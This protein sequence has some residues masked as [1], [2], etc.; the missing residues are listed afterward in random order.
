MTLL[1][2]EGHG[3]AGGV[4]ADEVVIVLCLSMPRV[5]TAHSETDGTV[6]LVHEDELQFRSSGL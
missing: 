4:C 5:T 6:F 3:D 2:F 1:T